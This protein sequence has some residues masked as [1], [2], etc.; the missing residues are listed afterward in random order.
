M[1]VLTADRRLIVVQTCN[2]AMSREL[3]PDYYVAASDGTM[4]PRCDLRQYEVGERQPREVV[5]L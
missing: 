2:E 1:K 5:T 4:V 3:L